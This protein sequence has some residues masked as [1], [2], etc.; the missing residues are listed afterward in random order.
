[1]PM[2]ITP[3][4][5]RT[6]DDGG[7]LVDNG[8]LTPYADAMK[9]IGSEEQVAVIDL[10]GSSRALAEKL[11]PEASRKLASKPGDATHFN[12][13]G[14]RDMAGLVPKELPAVEPRPRRFLKTP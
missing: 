6:F 8:N 3:M 13:K 7:K 14:A 11:G 9:E 2:L 12:E 1:M 5:P 4:V 10:L